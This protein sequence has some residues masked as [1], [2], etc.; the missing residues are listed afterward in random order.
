M[1]GTSLDAWYRNLRRYSTVQHAG[2]ERRPAYVR[3][4]AGVRDAI[5]VSADAGGYEVLRHCFGGRLHLQLNGPD[6]VTKSGARAASG[7]QTQSRARHW[8]KCLVERYSFD[9]PSLHL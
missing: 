1:A 8:A 4:F 9:D 2:F 6:S 5:P 7:P 3:G